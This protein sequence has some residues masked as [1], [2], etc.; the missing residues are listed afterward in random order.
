MQN[1]GWF[2]VGI[3]IRDRIMCRFANWQLWPLAVT[4]LR[5]G[6]ILT[7]GH[8]FQGSVEIP[9]EFIGFRAFRYPWRSL[10]FCGWEPLSCTLRTAQK[11]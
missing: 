1:Y 3:H 6:L 8:P 7:R 2:R 5:T 10:G 11:H 4:V 9:S